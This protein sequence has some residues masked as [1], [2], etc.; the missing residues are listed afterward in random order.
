MAPELFQDNGVYSYQSDFWSLAC[1]MMEMATGKPPFY[2]NSLK[3]LIQKIVVQEVQPVSGFSSEFNDLVQKMLQKDPVN[4][5]NWDEVKNHPWWTT[6][7]AQTKK[8]SPNSKFESMMRQTY[9]FTER[10]YQPQLQ[11]DK[12]LQNVRKIDPAV[13]YQMRQ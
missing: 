8:K 3:E 11:F 5:I 12:Y 6:P 2:T 10:I 1:I 9:S 13:Y 4:R 7:A